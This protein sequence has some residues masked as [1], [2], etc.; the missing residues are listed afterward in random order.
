MIKLEDILTLIKAVSDSDLTEVKIDFKDEKEDLTFTASKVRKEESGNCAP[1]P[2]FSQRTPLVPPP[3]PPSMGEACPIPAI[4]TPL[5]KEQAPANGE[6][7]TSPMVGTF[8]NA[9][10]E[11]EEPFVTVGDTVKKGQVVGIIE[12]MKLMNEI[13]ATCD[14]VVEKILVENKKMVGFGDE[15]MLIR[16]K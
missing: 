13:E 16:T 1:Q 5:G 12:A 8:Y 6:Y 10:G 11:G 3:L 7:I 15:L 9:P 4:F 14:G 2:I